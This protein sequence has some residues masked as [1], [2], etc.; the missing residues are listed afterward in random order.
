[1]IHIYFVFCRV[2][3]CG[4]LL[5]IRDFQHCEGRLY[6]CLHHVCMNISEID[7]PCCTYAEGVLLIAFPVMAQHMNTNHNCHLLKRQFSLPPL[8]QACKQCPRT[9]VKEKNYYHFM[10]RFLIF[11]FRQNLLMFLQP[12]MV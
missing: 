2:S 9:S 4:L 3:S 1:M 8:N 11:S 7:F 6:E 5:C 12:V 10:S